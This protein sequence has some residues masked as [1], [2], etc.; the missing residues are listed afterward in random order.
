MEK[1]ETSEFKC[2]AVCSAKAVQRAIWICQRF[3]LWLA[4]NLRSLSLQISATAVRAVQSDISYKQLVPAWPG[5]QGRDNSVPSGR[6]FGWFLVLH[7]WETNQIFNSSWLRKICGWPLSC[8]DSEHGFPSTSAH[9]KPRFAPFVFM[10]QLSPCRS[11]TAAV[12]FQPSSI[13][14]WIKNTS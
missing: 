10:G 7:K 6:S 11:E 5:D 4:R 9:F 1:G 13:Q 12:R 14:C 2:L 3:I 8:L